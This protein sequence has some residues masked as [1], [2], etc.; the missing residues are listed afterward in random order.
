MLGSGYELFP[1]L[2]NLSGEFNRVLSICLFIQKHSFAFTPHN[3]N[4]TLKR[5]KGKWFYLLCYSLA[6]R[7]IF[8]VPRD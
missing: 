5:V 7:T 4:I 2:Q 3:S 8:I 6:L 1:L